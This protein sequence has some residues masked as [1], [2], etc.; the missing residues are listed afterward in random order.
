MHGTP[1]RHKT[2]SPPHPLPP[3]AE[4][5]RHKRA[6]LRLRQLTFFGS[7]GLAKCFA[8]WRGNAR[9]RM[10]RRRRHA[11][12]RRLCAACP[13]FAAPLAQATAVLDQLR[14]TRAVHVQAGRLCSAAD[15]GEQQAAW[16]ARQAKPALEAAAV[17]SSAPSVQAAVPS[18]KASHLVAVGSSAVMQTA[19]Y[20]PTQAQLARIAEGVCT[21]VEARAAEALATVQPHELGDCIGASRLGGG[22]WWWPGCQAARLRVRLASAWA[23]AGCRQ[24]GAGT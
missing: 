13:T 15:W 4:W 22:A 5:L 23:G 1:H 20:L 14:G 24:G 16:R 8:L 21:S 12:S 10:L 6:F 17:S 2:R 19:S 3:T 18:S 7:F 11:L 9:G